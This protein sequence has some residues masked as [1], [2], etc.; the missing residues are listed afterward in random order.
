MSRRAKEYS[1]LYNSAL[2]E[3]YIAT[4]QNKTEADS[5]SA[6]FRK[7]AVMEKDIDKDLCQMGTSELKIALDQLL[8][9]RKD[10]AYAVLKLLRAYV[11]Y[12]RELGIR[13]VTFAMDSYT[14][15][16]GDRSRDLYVANALDLAACHDSLYS[17]IDEQTSDLILRGYEWLAFMGVPEASIP[18]ISTSDVDLT[19]RSVLD[20]SSGHTYYIYRE[21]LPVFEALVSADKFRIVHHQGEDG[22]VYAS[23]ARKKGDKLLRSIKKEPTT[24]DLQKNAAAARRAMTKKGKYVRQL[25]YGKLWESGW[26]S[27]LFEAER[28]RLL[29][30]IDVMAAE[31][32]R[33]H[34]FNEETNPENTLLNVEKRFKHAYRIWKAAF[35]V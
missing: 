23:Y 10:D 28:A 6:A 17:A 32:C 31:Y 22:P 8:K 20:R 12:C 9:N 35:R 1:G 25:N 7:L 33:T 11:L 26:Y 15:E 19:A 2:K 24:E 13:G 14:P 34:T 29:V 27:R 21:S 4:L 18:N 30:S 5:C 3:A 16:I